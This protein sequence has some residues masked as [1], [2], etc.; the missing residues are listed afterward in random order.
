MCST[1]L[2]LPSYEMNS[3]L[4][5]CLDICARSISSE[6]GDRA[7]LRKA[8]LIASITILWCLHHLREI[9][10]LS[11]NSHNLSLDWREPFWWDGSLWLSSVLL[12][13]SGNS[14]WFLLRR[15]PHTF[16]SKS[17]TCLRKCSSSWSLLSWRSCSGMP[18]VDWYDY[19][20]P[21]PELGHP[22][23]Y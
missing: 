9:D 23:S 14:L 22:P 12:D 11:V 19:E 17:L 16:N 5:N 6:N 13:L 3:G 15:L 8:R 10:N 4:L 1:G 18:D 7:A 2:A 20:D 21:S